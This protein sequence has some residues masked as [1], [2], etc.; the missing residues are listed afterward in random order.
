[1]TYFALILILLKKQKH[2]LLLTK[3]VNI[4]LVV[5]VR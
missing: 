2:Y 5:K 3:F 1:M 4:E